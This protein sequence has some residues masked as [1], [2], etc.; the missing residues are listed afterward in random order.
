MN[1]I[2]N[3]ALPMQGLDEEEL[4]QKKLHEAR[5]SLMTAYNALNDS[6]ERSAI[7]HRSFPSEMSMSDQGDNKSGSKQSEKQKEQIRRE[8][9]ANAMGK[10]AGGGSGMDVKGLLDPKQAVAAYHVQRSH[11]L[12]VVRLLS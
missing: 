3:A 7:P 4:L 10:A 1:W 6:Y 8:K 11:L 2:E 12:T 5:G 9:E